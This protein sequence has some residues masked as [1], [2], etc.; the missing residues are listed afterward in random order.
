VQRG[1]EHAVDAFVVAVADIEGG[2]VIATVD[3]DDMQR[4]ASQGPEVARCRPPSIGGRV[5]LSAAR[6]F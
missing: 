2:A 1:S 4:L 6:M 3:L 5:R